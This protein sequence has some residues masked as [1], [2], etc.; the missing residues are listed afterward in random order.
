[1]IIVQCFSLL[2]NPVLFS[3]IDTVLVTYFKLSTRKSFTAG[4]SFK[5]KTIY[6]IV[7]MWIITYIGTII[8][9]V[10][11]GSHVTACMCL[12]CTL[13]YRLFG[14]KDSFFCIYHRKHLTWE[15]ETQIFTYK[16]YKQQLH[17]MNSAPAL[18]V[19]PS[20]ELSHVW[21]KFM[22]KPTIKITVHEGSVPARLLSYILQQENTVKSRHTFGQRL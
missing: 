19:L 20:E 3:G 16:Q 11:L 15:Y 10:F 9:F 17:H 8:I 13:N 2:P 21:G 14:R 22:H 7:H 5:N 4:I 12:V 18:E 1:M 6:E